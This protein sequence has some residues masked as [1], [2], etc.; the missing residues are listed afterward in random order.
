MQIVTKINENRIP[1]G[2]N[3]DKAGIMQRRLA[4]FMAKKI[5]EYWLD[6]WFDQLQPR[7]KSTFITS[8]APYVLTKPTQPKNEYEKLNDQDLQKTC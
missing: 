2:K 8:M 1:R 5:T 7:D 3:S 4:R 6:E